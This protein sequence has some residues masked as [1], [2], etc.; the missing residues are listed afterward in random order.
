MRK[1]LSAASELALSRENPEIAPLH[2]ASVMFED[3]AGVAA[4]VCR[5][6]GASLESVRSALSAALTKLPK[7]SPPP[8]TLS[9]NSALIRVLR[10]A[11]AA[12]KKVSCLMFLLLAR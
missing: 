8:D 9:P 2:M 7:Q 3:A 10:A 5:K 11:Q 6:A 4:S 1:S 12:S